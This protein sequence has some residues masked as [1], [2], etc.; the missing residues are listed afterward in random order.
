MG[1]SGFLAV[2]PSRFHPGIFLIEVLA[3]SLNWPRV[4][5]GSVAYENADTTVLGQHLKDKTSISDEAVIDS[6]AEQSGLKYHFMCPQSKEG[7]CLL[8]IRQGSGETVG[9]VSKQVWADII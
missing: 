2:F 5:N 7:N 3:P 8:K 9:V 1:C 6:S 4:N